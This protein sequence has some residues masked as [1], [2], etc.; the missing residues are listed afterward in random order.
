M[1]V[2]RLA[3][4]ER[5][6][7]RGERVL[8]VVEARAAA[9]ST[10]TRSIAV[11]EVEG[12]RRRGRAARSRAAA[13]SSGGARVAAARAAVV[14]EVPDV[15]REVVVGVPAAHAEARVGGVRRGRRARPRGRRCR[16]GR[17]VGWPA[18]SDG[19]E[20]VVGRHD[21]RRRG[22]EVGDELAPALGH[23]LELAVA[24]ELVAE[25]VAERDRARLEL[26]G[27]RR[28]RGLVALEQPELGGSPPRARASAEAMP[29]ARLAP[30]LL[31]ASRD[32][33]AQH[34]GEQ[35]ARRRLAV[36]GR[37]EHAAARQA[38]GEPLA[39]RRARAPSSTRPGQRRA[40]AAAAR[41]RRE[42]RRPEPRA[43]ASLITA[44]SP[45][46]RAVVVRGTASASA[47]RRG[48]S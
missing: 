30:A 34:L 45:S 4:H 32:A 19:G 6:R 16:S 21:E 3:E 36:R 8:D 18:A 24:V 12:G 31:R 26:R 23:E 46:T 29:E 7:R 42:R 43:S 22:V 40:A 47:P 10:R 27:D 17:R 13:R 48:C 35:R 37:D 39:A 5:E 38:R 28:Q 1:T 25:E 11:A 44:G 15:D 9:S 14:A 2:E 41:A 33:A 20:R